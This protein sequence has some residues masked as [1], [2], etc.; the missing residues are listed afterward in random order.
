MLKDDWT[1]GSRIDHT[2]RPRPGQPGHHVVP[3]PFDEPGVP[4]QITRLEL[5]TCVVIGWY[6][7]PALVGKVLRRLKGGQSPSGQELSSRGREKLIPLIA[8][9]HQTR[10]VVSGF[11][12][13]GLGQG[14][15]LSGADDVDVSR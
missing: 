7:G 11:D 15:E 6:W 2:D 9:S 8:C 13:R 4:G 1:G 12:P 10:Q 5:S 14:Q 3:G